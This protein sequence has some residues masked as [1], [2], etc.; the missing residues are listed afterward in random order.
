LLPSIPNLA[1]LYGEKV[2]RIEEELGYPDIPAEA[3]SVL[4]SMIKTIIGPPG[5]KPGEVTLKLHG[6][7]AAILAVAEGA[8]NKAGNP[9]SRIKIS[10]VA[11]LDSTEI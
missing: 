9:V 7:L 2:R 11:G 8:K 4:R 10:V 5:D 3:T 1:R 6:E